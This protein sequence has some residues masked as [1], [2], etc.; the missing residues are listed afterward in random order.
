MIVCPSCK[1]K[2]LEGALFCSECG[3]QLSYQ[4]RSPTDT[5]DYS[6]MATGKKPKKGSAA[7]VKSEGTPQASN[8]ALLIVDTGTMLPLEGG[9]EFTLGRVSG[10]Q[11]ILP[12]I[13]LT[14]FH[15]YENGVS[16]L[17]ATVKV[18]EGNIMISDL[19]SANG[20]R[21]NGQRIPAHTPQQLEN[22]DILT[23]G[24]FKL[25]VLFQG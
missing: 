12:D 6:R 2:E 11:P 3:A 9:A 17:H 16:R 8:L 23:L 5:V 14:P 10:T 15:A 1:H 21:V 20:T 25:Q 19:G 22:G 18:A 24:K 7:N 13:D 4:K